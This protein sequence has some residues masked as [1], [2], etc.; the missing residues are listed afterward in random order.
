MIRDISSHIMKEVVKDG[1]TAVNGPNDHNQNSIEIQQALDGQY[2]NGE[3]VKTPAD[4]SKEERASPALHSNKL[5]PLWDQFKL[6]LDE[7]TF[8]SVVNQTQRT[9]K[10]RVQRYR[11]RLPVNHDRSLERL[12]SV[13]EAS[14]G[15]TTFRHR[16]M[17]EPVKKVSSKYEHT[18]MASMN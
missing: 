1:N 16:S 12:K 9:G 3:V 5:K 15:A 4:R 6:H 7:D 13:V 14:R 10:Q 11:E 8:R 17:A 18:T 2:Q